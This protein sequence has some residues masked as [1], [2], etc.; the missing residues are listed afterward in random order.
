MVPDDKPKIK[1]MRTY[2]FIVSFLAVI[3]IAFLFE[4]YPTIVGISSFGIGLAFKSLLVDGGTSG[5]K[6]GEDKNLLDTL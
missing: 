1:S 2:Y 3:G 6:Q 5:K 4:S